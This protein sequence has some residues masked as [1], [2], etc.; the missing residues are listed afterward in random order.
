MNSEKPQPD[1]LTPAS[2]FQIENDGLG[3]MRIF[4]EP[5]G[6]EFRLAPSKVIEVHLFGTVKPILLT[7]S[8]DDNGRACVSLWPDQGR[9]KA[10]FEGKDIWDCLQP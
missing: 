6:A 7:Q 5:E 10:F 8:V 4:L 3:D 9:Y 2:I 1:T